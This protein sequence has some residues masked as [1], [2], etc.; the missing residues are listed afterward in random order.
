MV[1]PV[2]WWWYAAVLTGY[3][4][5]SQ[6]KQRPHLVGLCY[7][8]YTWAEKQYHM[9]AYWKRNHR[10][11]YIFVDQNRHILFSQLCLCKQMTVQKMEH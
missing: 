11:F 8:R 3:R 9:G 7:S 4:A 10:L 1:L 6:A 5:S 2:L